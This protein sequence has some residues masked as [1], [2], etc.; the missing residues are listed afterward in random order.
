[1]KKK[2]L[3]V[4]ILHALGTKENLVYFFQKMKTK[5]LIGLQKKFL[6]EKE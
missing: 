4:I 1:M 6:K 5:F 2:L 3:L